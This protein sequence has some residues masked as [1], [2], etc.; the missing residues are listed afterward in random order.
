MV[1]FVATVENIFLMC[2]T[3]RCIECRARSR[4]VDLA[5]AVDDDPRLHPAIF[6]RDSRAV[7]YRQYSLAEALKL[8][9]S[10][11]VQEGD[12]LFP[13]LIDIVANDGQVS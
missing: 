5:Q 4:R 13:I 1:I 11:Q 7:G 3:G 9:D 2:L 6:S 10:R 8:L 12:I